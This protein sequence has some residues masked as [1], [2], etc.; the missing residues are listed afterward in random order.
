MTLKVLQQFQD[1]IVLLLG[2]DTDEGLQLLRRI[3][4]I[5]DQ[6]GYFGLLLKDM[7]EAE[8]VRQSVEEKLLTLASLSMFVLLE[9]SEPG[10]QI[11]ELSILA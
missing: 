4:T 9:D 10:G 11:T 5:L 7:S 6:L 1:G 8:F 3:Q 2:R